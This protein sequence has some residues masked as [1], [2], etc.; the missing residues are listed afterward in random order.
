MGASIFPQSVDVLT[1][2]MT[3]L[4]ERHKM[5]ADNIAN[6]GTPFYTAKRAPVEE[7]QQALS[8]AIT[9]QKRHPERPLVLDGM[10]H[11]RETG[12]G[13]EIAP[14][15]SNPGSAGILR[16]DQNN[17]DLE[18]EMSDLA[19]NTLMHRVMSDLL[20]KQFLMLKNAIAERVDA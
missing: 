1:K 19:Q 18:T 11:V 12:Q 17:L 14:L 6:A 10:R 2:S 5:I 8:R 7:F 15:E 3:F 4:E 20:H 13:L 9:V 16:H